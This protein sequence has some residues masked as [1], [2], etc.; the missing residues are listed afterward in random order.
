MKRRNRVPS[1]QILDKTSFS[2]PR[3]R[4][5]RIPMFSPSWT[6]ILAI[7]RML[8]PGQVFSKRLEILQKIST[9]ISKA[10]G[11]DLAKIGELFQCLHIDSK[12]MCRPF[13]TKHSL[14]GYLNYG[15]DFS[16]HACRF[17]RRSLRR[18]VT[19]GDR[20]RW[21]LSDTSPT[22]SSFASP[23]YPACLLIPNRASF[24]RV[25]STVRD[26]FTPFRN[27]NTIPT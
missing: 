5:F 4:H 19:T 6:R 20:P 26:R 22:F 16:C 10:I 11:G 17:L 23:R 24:D 1:G 9:T 8:P 3:W 14:R 21:R 18:M 7:R 12:I 15:K 25:S 13:W 27:H 2:C